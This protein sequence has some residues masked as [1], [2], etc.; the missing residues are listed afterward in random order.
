[1]PNDGTD[2]KFLAGDYILEVFCKIVDKEKHKK[3]LSINLNL[4]ENESKELQDISK[5]LYFDWS[6]DSNGYNKLIKGLPI[7]DS[8]WDTINIFDR[9]K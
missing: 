5:G 2:Y 6:P 3:L 9:K 8:K 1:L 7:Q 4:N